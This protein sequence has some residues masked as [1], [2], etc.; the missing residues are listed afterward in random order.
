MKTKTL[1]I[2][3]LLFLNYSLY[4]QIQCGTESTTNTTY[5]RNAAKSYSVRSLDGVNFCFNVYFHTL[6]S[7][8][9]QT[10]IPSYYTGAML[11]KLNEDYEQ[12]NIS[13]KS[14]GTGYINNSH[15]PM[16]GLRLWR[17]YRPTF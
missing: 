12:Y 5:Q 7:D 4:A 11:D 17:K 6:R 16:T 13:F 15:I 2:G 10:S 3:V 9:G 14:L 1:S 8:A